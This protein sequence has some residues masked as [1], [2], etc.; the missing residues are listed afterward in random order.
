MKIRNAK[1]E[2]IEDVKNLIIEYTKFLN[3]NLDFQGLKD[4]LEDLRT[5][6]SA[7]EGE[8]LVAVSDDNEIIGQNPVKGTKV[9]KGDTLTLYIPN[10]VDKFPDMAGEGWSLSDAQTFCD[11]YE[12]ILEKTEQETSAYSPGTII[13]QSRTAG[14]TIIKGTTFRVTVAVKPKQ[15]EEVKPTPTPTPTPTPSGG[16]SGETGDETTPT[17][18][19]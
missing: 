9:K 19:E 14:T 10:I 1:S 12:L 5:K 18:G 16:D 2:E 4:E 7:V 15:K 6:Y 8:L 3:R 17:D 11:K 13:S